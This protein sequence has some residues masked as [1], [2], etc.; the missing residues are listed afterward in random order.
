M[1]VIAGI[2]GSREAA[3]AASI[4]MNLALWEM[5]QRADGVA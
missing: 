1:L 4:P 3:T 5:H 2:L